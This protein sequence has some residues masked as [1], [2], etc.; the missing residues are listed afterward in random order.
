MVKA[1]IFD[2]FGVLYGGSLFT[3][4]NLAPLDRRQ[5]LVDLNKQN[6][7]G[8]LDFEDYVSG[9]ADII[10]RTNSEVKDIFAQKRVRNQPLFDFIKEIKS[11][12]V[13]IGLL[14]NAGKD[15]PGALFN[16][17][18]LNGEL[19]D[20][21]VISSEIGYA[22]P[23]ADIY[24]HAAKKIGIPNSDCIFIDDVFENCHGAEMTDMK[25]V[26][27]ADNETAKMHVREFLES[28]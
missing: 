25:A 22:K 20:A 19:F 10:G 5:E 2:C 27:F 26:W 7:R 28:N 3:L 9:V 24:N 13:K 15:M 14:S 1:V 18:E 21:V 17:S 4:L 11:P 6:D 12:Q 8:Y 16:D 23:S